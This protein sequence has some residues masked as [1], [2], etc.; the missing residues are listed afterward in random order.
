MKEQYSHLEKRN[1]L[2]ISLPNFGFV[3]IPLSRFEVLLTFRGIALAAISNVVM[4]VRVS[5][6]MSI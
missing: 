5:D 6:V 4:R 1:S 2:T 3:M